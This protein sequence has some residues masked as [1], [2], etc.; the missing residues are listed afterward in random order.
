MGNIMNTP[1]EI[2]EGN[3][4]T[5]VYKV[6]LPLGKMILKGMLA[7]AF[8]AL[9]GAASSTAGHAIENVG[10]ARSLSGA[11]FG[12][13]LMLVLFMG[14]DLLTTIIQIIYATATG[15]LFATIV[16]KGKSLWPSIITHSVVNALSVFTIS[17]SFTKIFSP[18]CLTLIPI[19]YAVYLNKM[20]KVVK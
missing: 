7:G 4:N 5:G 15:Y 2:V 10:V 12:V 20:I 8:I 11:V 17:T 1:A 13:G 16:V 3:I 19:V 14:A 18:I 6:N 9:A